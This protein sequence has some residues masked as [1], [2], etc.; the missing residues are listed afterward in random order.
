MRTALTQRGASFTM[1]QDGSLKGKVRLIFNGQEALIHRLEENES[2]E[3][4]RTK[5]LEEELRRMLPATATVHLD[6]AKG[7]SGQDDPVDAT[8]SLEIPGYA[9]ATGKR[10]ILPTD[11]FE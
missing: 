11:L 6:S 2:D 7:W 3:A 1:A 8:F 4:E 10:L 9:T 5:S